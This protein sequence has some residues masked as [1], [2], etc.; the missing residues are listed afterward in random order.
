MVAPHKKKVA[1]NVPEFVKKA[2]TTMKQEE[3][4]KVLLDANGEKD[5]LAHSVACNASGEVLHQPR[6]HPYKEF[7]RHCQGRDGMAQRKGN[8]GRIWLV[9]VGPSMFG[10]AL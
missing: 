10:A 2:W 8:E 6:G 1:L 7:F 3:V 4:A 5:T 9:P